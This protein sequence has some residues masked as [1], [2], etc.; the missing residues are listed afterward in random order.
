MR[1]LILGAPGAGK[2]TQAKTLSEM[3]DVP[4]IS[5][6]DIFRDN[7]KNHTKLGQ[8]VKEI[9]E[10]GGLVPDVITNEIAKE[11]LERE[12]CRKGYILDGYPRTIDQARYLDDLLDDS[13]EKLDYVI[14]I[15][16]SDECIID[17]LSKRR[18]CPACG[19][20]YHLLSTPPGEE[21]ICDICGAKIIQRADDKEET[22]R[23]RLR[24]YHEQTKPLIDY[25]K[26]KGLLVNIDGE[27]KIKPILEDILKIIGV[28]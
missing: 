11:R 9:L 16:S 1:L 26:Q 15:E 12:D 6:G 10:E 17:R 24:I 2:G 27:R 23:D 7:I 5:T 4:H 14:N 22:I 3:L 19:R 28:K 18:Y 21:G 25:Y 8:K 20:I 13:D